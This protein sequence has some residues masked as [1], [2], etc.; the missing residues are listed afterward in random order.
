MNQ[1]TLKPWN[2]CNIP[3]RSSQNFIFF[4]KQ[5]TFKGKEIV[6][7]RLKELTTVLKEMDAFGKEYNLWMLATVSQCF[8]KFKNAFNDGVF[9]TK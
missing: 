5:I 8:I 7:F 4:W 3:S 9:N 2:T 6:T 1:A